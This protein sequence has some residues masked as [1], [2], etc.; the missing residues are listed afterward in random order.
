MRTFLI[1]YGLIFL[2]GCL[3]AQEGYD[4]FKGKK[5]D[6][7]LF[8]DFNPGSRTFWTG[9]D[10]LQKG[11]LSYGLYQFKSLDQL[12]RF[13]APFFP[14][15]VKQDFELECLLAYRHPKLPFG[16]VWGDSAD[17]S[18]L[19]F[20]QISNKGYFIISNRY[21]ILKKGA[22]PVKVYKKAFNKLTV[23]KYRRHYYIFVNEIFV[24]KMPYEKLEQFR[25]GPLT[26]P[27][28]Y[29][30]VEYLRISYLDPFLKS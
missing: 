17:P 16:M 22:I 10:G 26:G 11:A 29:I 4:D 21:E 19:F 27:R 3:H 30:L 13:N 18:N 20:F 25:A 12:S 24:T 9:N 15:D 7:I 1:I 6:H 5:K 8:E 2:A 28:G 23:R 14:I